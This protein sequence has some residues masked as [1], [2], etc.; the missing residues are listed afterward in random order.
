M[1][2]VLERQIRRIC[3]RERIWDIALSDYFTRRS[4]LLI[5]SPR[6]KADSSRARARA[7]TWPSALEVAM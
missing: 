4:R 6:A 3:I 1:P 2:D 7:G 5:L